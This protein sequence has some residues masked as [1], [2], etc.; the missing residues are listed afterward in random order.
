MSL[1]SLIRSL[2]AHAL[3]AFVAAGLLL[4][5]AGLAA[6]GLEGASFGHGHL[7]QAHERAIHH[8]HLF[9]GSHEHPAPPTDHDH[10]ESDHP[11]TPAPEERDSPGRTVTVSTNPA[12]SH[13]VTPG[14]LPAPA[15][16][17]LSLV[18]ALALPLVARPPARPTAPRGPPASKRTPR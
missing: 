5:L 9:L 16:D 10:H 14:G 2:R 13:P 6:A 1:P 18:L 4:A 15:A 7:E 11:E 17:P 8:H 3:D 12:L